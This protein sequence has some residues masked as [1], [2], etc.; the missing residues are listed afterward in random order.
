MND[1]RRVKITDNSVEKLMENVNI[2][3]HALTAL[4]TLVVLVMVEAW[5]GA[6][7]LVW[8][9]SSRHSFYIEKTDTSAGITVNTETIFIQNIG[10]KPATKV[11]AI[12]LFKP[13]YINVQPRHDS[14]ENETS[15]GHYVMTFESLGKGETIEIQILYYDATPTLQQIRSDNGIAR[16][17]PVRLLRVFPN[18]FNYGVVGFG[19]IGLIVVMVTLAKLSLV[20]WQSVPVGG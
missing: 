13:P 9:G 1:R 19:A 18:W 2:A 20:A 14:T 5:R 6:P 3:S 4:F 8:Y 10:R 7:R 17:I 15:D 11:K 16:V 12:F